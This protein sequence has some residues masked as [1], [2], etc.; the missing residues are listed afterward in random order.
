MKSQTRMRRVKSFGIS[1]GCL[2]ML[3]IGFAFSALAQTRTTILSNGPNRMNL[4]LLSEGYRDSEKA[5]FLEDAT[6]VVRSFLSAQPYIE[7]QTYFNA[8]AIFIASSESGSDHP[9]YPLTN[10]TYFNSSYD[11]EERLITIPLD[12]TGKGKV[13]A[14]IR[15]QAPETHLTILIVNDLVFGGGGGPILITSRNVTSREIVIHESGHTLAGLGDEYSD[16]FPGFPDVEEPNTTRETN[17][18]SIKWKAWISPSTPVPTPESFDYASEVGLFQGAHYQSNGWYRPKLDCGMRHLGVPFCEVCTEALVKAICKRV[19]LIESFSPAALKFSVGATQTVVFHVSPLQPASHNLAIQWLTN[20]ISVAGAT[21]ATFEL[22]VAALPKGTYLIRAQI[23]DPTSLVRNDPENVLSNSLT[24][25]MT[26]TVAA[27]GPFELAKGKYTGL[28]SETD[29]RLVSS[30]LINL[31]L[32]ANG[33]FSGKLLKPDGT[34][35]FKGKFDPQNHA[36]ISIARP[37]KTPL[38][39]NLDIEGGIPQIRGTVSDGDWI[40]EIQAN[41]D[42]AIAE[43]AQYTFLIPGKDD[44]QNPAG[45][46]YGS[47]LLRPDGFVRLTGAVADGTRLRYSVKKPNSGDLPLFVRLYGGKGMLLSW[48]HLSDEVIESASVN[49]IKESGAPGKFYLDGFTNE[50]ALSGERYDPP[51]SGQPALGL[52]N[53]SLTFERGN[54]NSPLTD[55][56]VLSNNRF[57]FTGTNKLSLAIAPATGLLK[58]RFLHPVTRKMTTLQGTILQKRK[59]A[60]GFFLG[61]NESGKVTLQKNIQ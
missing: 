56:G 21:N 18:N 53:V 12:Q 32:S 35:S 60:G 20:G 31:T 42:S 29:V 28:F 57:A 5:L 45:D 36:P 27:P 59:E 48:I 54:L 43:V 2:T 41:R 10:S 14:L 34:S 49:W 37:S 55:Q 51:S 23:N 52:T 19:H 22:P 15:A 40:S 46:G 58:G 30:G 38:T 11:L 4:T 6:N 17:R 8:A 9:A 47:A 13:D 26:K 24:W 3:L 61:T 16:S 33:S 39:M 50:T 25:R 1:L 7:Y 44:G